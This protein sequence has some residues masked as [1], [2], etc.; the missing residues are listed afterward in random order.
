MSSGEFLYKFG[1]K[2]NEMVRSWYMYEVTNMGMKL[3]RSEEPSWMRR[4]AFLLN[5]NTC[6]LIEHGEVSWTGRHPSLLDSKTCCS[7]QQYDHTH[8]PPRRHNLLFFNGR[9]LP[10]QQDTHSS[11]KARSQVLPLKADNCPLAQQRHTHR[12]KQS[13]RTGFKWR[14]KLPD[15][16]SKKHVWHNVREQ[17][18]KKDTS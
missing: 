11:C 10:A 9:S 8:C 7:F 16:L 1:T 4:Q 3:V 14:P 2:I 13:E 6:H 17:R 12:Q 15:T 18:Q 5:R